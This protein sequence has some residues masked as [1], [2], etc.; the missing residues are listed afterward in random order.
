[1]E[2][3]PGKLNPTDYLSRHPPR[4]NAEHHK[5]SK[6]R[7]QVVKA[8]V[9]ESIPDA[10]TLTEILGATRSNET[11]KKLISYISPGRFNAC[12]KDPNTKCYSSVFCELSNINGI[13]LH[14]EQVVF[15]HSLQEQVVKISH[16]GHQG[17]VLTKAIS[18]FVCMV[19]G[20][21]EKL[22]ERK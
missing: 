12:K 21:S 22:A 4:H 10:I 2:Y 14:G 13:L 8:I 5:N 9:K 16:E 20:N 1:M 17:I 11:P 7:E 19:P 18:T 3:Q 15:P 6:K